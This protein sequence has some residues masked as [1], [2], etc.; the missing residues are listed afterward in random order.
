[1]RFVSVRRSDGG[2]TL[3]VDDPLAEAIAAR[4]GGREAPGAVVDALLSMREVFSDELAGDGTLR[5]LLVELVG[6]LGRDGAA[7]TAAGVAAE[8]DPAS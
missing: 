7:R 1:M 4:L 3:A 8:R 5:A 2:R 6:R